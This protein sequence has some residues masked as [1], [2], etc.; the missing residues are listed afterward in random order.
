M[1]DAHKAA[2][3]SGPTTLFDP[4]LKMND[5]DDGSIA[6]HN[7]SNPAAVLSTS[8]GRSMWYHITRSIVEPAAY[9]T[10]STMSDTVATNV[11]AAIATSR[12]R[13]CRTRYI[14]QSTATT[15][16]TSLTAT[17]APAAR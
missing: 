17:S 7:P 2:G 9:A 4:K 14:A 13:R 10:G 16:G 12:R 15:P 1:F 5:T 8:R 11:A 3:A 6:C